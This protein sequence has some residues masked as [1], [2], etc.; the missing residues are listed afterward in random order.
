[1]CDI[2]PKTPITNVIYII[3]MCKYKVTGMGK[4]KVDIGEEGQSW[5]CESV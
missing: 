3:L 5:A 4:Q 2:A 1:M